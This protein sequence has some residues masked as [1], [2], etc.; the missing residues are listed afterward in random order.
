MLDDLKKQ[1][2]LL[3]E[4]DEKWKNKIVDYTEQSKLLTEKSLA[5]GVGPEEE[6]KK[7][8]LELQIKILSTR[9][10]KTKLNE[11]VKDLIEEINNTQTYKILSHMLWLMVTKKEDYWLFYQGIY[12][13][14]P[15]ALKENPQNI[16]SSWLT[17]SFKEK[18]QAVKYNEPLEEIVYQIILGQK[19]SPFQMLKYSTARFKE[20]TFPDCGETSLR[21]LLR[22]FL[23]RVGNDNKTY[24]DYQILNKMGV[25]SR[26]VSPLLVNFFKKYADENSQHSEPARHDWAVVVSNLNHLLGEKIHYRIESLDTNCN[27][28]GVSHNMLKVIKKLFKVKSWQELAVVAAKASEKPFTIEEHLDSEGFG[29]LDVVIDKEK[30]IWHLNQHH[31]FL[32]MAGVNNDNYTSRENYQS[33]YNDPLKRNILSLL[34]DNSEKNQFIDSLAFAKNSFR[35][36]KYLALQSENTV[37]NF[38]SSFDFTVKH[39]KKENPGTK[40][41][42]VYQGNL[43]IFKNLYKRLTLA[44]AKIRF[45]RQLKLFL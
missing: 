15:T 42:F 18:S 33:L 31:F 41:P 1:L 10:L 26:A 14:N 12:Q 2:T 44:D 32:E 16:P 21:N 20:V 7:D 38:L 29:T 19:Q 45:L 40:T 37:D 28:A 17:D 5:L 27:I 43:S 23:L 11:V 30:Y 24:Y 22:A 39:M 36:L 8:Q 4:E 13:Q 9:E 6:K 35:P 25:K 34:P 3:M